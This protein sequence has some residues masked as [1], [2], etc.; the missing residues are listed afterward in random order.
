MSAQRIPVTIKIL[1]KTLQ[2]GCSPD[3]RDSLLDAADLVNSLLADSASSYTGA[4]QERLVMLCA[5]N[6]ANDLISLQRQAPVASNTIPAS[7]LERAEKA[8]QASVNPVLGA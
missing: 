7:L 5:L 3:E 6:L 8:L 4:D 1:D 2:I